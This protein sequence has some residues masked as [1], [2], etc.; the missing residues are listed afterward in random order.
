MQAE[1]TLYEMTKKYGS[2]KGEAMMWKAVAAISEAVEEGMPE[3]RKHA[4]MRRIYGEMSDGHYNEEFAAEDIAKMYY[5]DRKGVRHQA[6]YWPSS[7]V[8]EIYEGVKG[9]IRPSAA[10]DFE[11]T[12]NMVA[13]DNWPLLEKWF[14]GM[15]DKERNEKTVELALNWLNDPDSPHPDSKIWNYLN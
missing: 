14:P 7:T 5:T 4:L 13:S 12:M 3:D 6:P 10:C 8:R 11:V 15:S 1:M 9:A 2:G